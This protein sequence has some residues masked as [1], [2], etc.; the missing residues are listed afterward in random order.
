M[1]S[2]ASLLLLM[3]VLGI[4]TT[5]W[6][7]ELC[8]PDISIN[9]ANPTTKQL[10]KVQIGL[11]VSN[12]YSPNPT[13]T[14]SQPRNNY[15][16]VDV[17]YNERMGKGTR[18]DTLDGSYSQLTLGKLPCGTYVVAVQVWVNCRINGIPAKMLGGTRSTSFSVK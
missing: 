9:P 13:V 16:V 2:R 17:V 11:T 12:T 3:M 14:V 18:H 8:T 15:Y 7:V 5:A 4:S 6:A 10:V 1:R